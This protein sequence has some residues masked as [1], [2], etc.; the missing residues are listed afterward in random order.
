MKK[1][2]MGEI[3]KVFLS[4]VLG[5]AFTFFIGFPILPFINSF[6]NNSYSAVFLGLS[7]ILMLS[8]TRYIYIKL[9]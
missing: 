9:R 8:M 4:I 2:K 5:A 7:L 6:N 1:A 3:Q